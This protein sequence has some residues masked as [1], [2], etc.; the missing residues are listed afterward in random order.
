MKAFNTGLNM[1]PTWTSTYFSVPFSNGSATAQLPGVFITPNASAKLPLYI[2]TG[3][4]DYP[5]EYGFFLLSFPT[6][7]DIAEQSDL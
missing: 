4:T 7:Y 2:I 6:T 5:K 1:H 3:G